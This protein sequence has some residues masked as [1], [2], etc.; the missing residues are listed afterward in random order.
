AHPQAHAADIDVVA[1]GSFGMEAGPQLEDGGNLAVDLQVAG[2]LV[3]GAGQDL[4]EG[5]LAGAVGADD[6]DDLA[7]I[8]LE[9]HVLEGPEIAVALLAGED[10]PEDVVRLGID[11]VQ[12]G[13]VARPNRDLA[14]RH[15]LVL[16]CD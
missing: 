4:E 12:F 16:R 7:A 6:A 2:G 11:L 13:E 9:G 14:R 3:E 1:P 15:A 8:D 5:A 10:L